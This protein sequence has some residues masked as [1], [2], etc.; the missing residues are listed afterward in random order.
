MS[1]GTDALN[2]GGSNIVTAPVDRRRLALRSVLNQR[3]S[4]QITIMPVVRQNADAIVAYRKGHLSV[5]HCHAKLLR[6]G[7]GRDSAVSLSGRAWDARGQCLCRRMVEHQI[8][9]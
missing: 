6:R 9:S 8:R 2:A 7:N 3:Q 4:E 1:Q 5:G